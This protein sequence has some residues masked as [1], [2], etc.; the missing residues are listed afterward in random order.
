MKNLILLSVMFLLIL[1]PQHQS[2]ARSSIPTTGKL[3]A[4]VDGDGQLDY[5]TFRL[6]GVRGGYNGSLAITSSKGRKLWEDV[7]YLYQKDLEEVLVHEGNIRRKALILGFFK[8]QLK[9]GGNLKFIKLRY[10]DL[11]DDWINDSASDNNIEPEE[12]KNHI[13]S[14]DKNTTLTYSAQWPEEQVQ[15]VYVSALKKFVRYA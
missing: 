4:D 8:G 5:L 7:W 2:S 12:L 14:Q 1:S 9:Y 6:E 15:I 10:E 13:L 11:Q 3:A